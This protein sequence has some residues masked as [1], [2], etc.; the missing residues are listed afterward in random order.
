MI[1]RPP[2]STLFPY[3]TLFRSRPNG[4]QLLK[5]QGQ[6]DQRP[7]TLDLLQTSYAEMPETQDGFDPAVDRLD[8][9]FSL[10]IELSPFR[11]FESLLHSAGGGEFLRR[12]GHRL[13][14]ALTPQRDQGTDE[15]S[16]Q[17]SKI[18]L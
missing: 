13:G 15:L 2:R 3:T 6:T 5:V 1:R 18:L 7:L 9:P 12:A 17:E 16:L 10:G 11:A 4:P 8:D 14:F